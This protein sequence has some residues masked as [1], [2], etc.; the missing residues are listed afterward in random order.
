MQ[1]NRELLA[2]R[3]VALIVMAGDHSRFEDGVLDVLGQLAP[4]FEYARAE[5]A[6]KSLV[7]THVAYSGAVPTAAGALVGRRRSLSSALACTILRIAKS[8]STGERR[9]PHNARIE[10]ISL[11]SVRVL[12]DTGRREPARA[13]ERRNK[14]QR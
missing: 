10:G 11:I 1:E 9:S 8:S 2:Q 6:G 14:Q 12:H 4:A 13:A 7:H 5:R 3:F